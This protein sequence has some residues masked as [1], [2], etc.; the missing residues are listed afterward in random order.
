MAFLFRKYLPQEPDD[1]SQNGDGNVEPE[2]PEVRHELEFTL[3]PPS[4]KAQIVLIAA[5][6]ILFNLI[7]FATFI[8]ALFLFRD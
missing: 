2:E 6:I 5:G 1:V 7:L 4:P 8:V 3:F